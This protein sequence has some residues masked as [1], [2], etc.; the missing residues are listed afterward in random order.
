MLDA[1]AEDE[2][3]FEYEDDDDEAG[4]EA[5]VENEYYVAKGRRSHNRLVSELMLCCRPQGRRS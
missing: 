1:G 3:D 4:G 2:Y 5:D